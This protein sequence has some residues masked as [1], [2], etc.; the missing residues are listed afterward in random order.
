MIS[1]KARNRKKLIS[2]FMRLVALL[3]PGSLSL[4]QI[5]IIRKLVLIASLRRLSVKNVIIEKIT[6]D[7]LELYRIKPNKLLDEKKILFFHGGGFFI[8]NIKIYRN[9]VSLLAKLLGREIIS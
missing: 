6:L 9:Y 4:F 5:K 3:K 8:G 7:Q 1:R 2:F